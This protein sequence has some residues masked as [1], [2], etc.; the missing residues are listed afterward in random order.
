MLGKRGNKTKRRADD[1]PVR[2]SSPVAYRIRERLF[3]SPLDQFRDEPRF[4]IATDLFKSTGFGGT[5]FF[6]MES[7]GVGV[8]IVPPE[9]TPFPQW[10]QPDAPQR[11]CQF[12]GQ[13]TGGYIRGFGR[14]CGTRW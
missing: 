2:E 3:Q 14:H 9:I 7:L 4:G 13:G 5:P 8:M 1:P 12:D 10:L 11:M 6:F